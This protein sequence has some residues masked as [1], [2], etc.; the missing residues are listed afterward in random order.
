MFLHFYQRMMRPGNQMD[1]QTRRGANWKWP[2]KDCMIF[3]Q[4]LAR[5]GME[6]RVAEKADAKLLLATFA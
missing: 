6:I 2:T 3:Y 5:M 4:F 1:D